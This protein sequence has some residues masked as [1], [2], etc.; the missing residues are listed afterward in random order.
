M[1]IDQSQRLITY[2]RKIPNI[3]FVSKGG[4]GVSHEK[5]IYRW[6]GPKLLC[7]D[8]FATLSGFAMTDSMVVKTRQVLREVNGGVEMGV[9][10]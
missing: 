10:G 1:D 2:D 7:I 3:P 4:D 8:L 6:G 9:S 5:L